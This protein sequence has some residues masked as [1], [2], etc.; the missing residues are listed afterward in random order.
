MNP[1]PAGTPRRSPAAFVL[2]DLM[3]GLLVAAAPALGCGAAGS[4]RSPIWAGIAVTLALAAVVRRES[5]ADGQAGRDLRLLLLALA[6]VNAATAVASAA[7]WG[8]ALAA[9]PLLRL[10]LGG[11]VVVVAAAR[12]PGWWPAPALAACA[13]ALSRAEVLAGSQPPRPG[14]CSDRLFPWCC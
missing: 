2:P 1:R 7:G 14:C 3:L 4:R 9:T 8:A 13:A 6:G 5:A 11:V 12:V 10:G